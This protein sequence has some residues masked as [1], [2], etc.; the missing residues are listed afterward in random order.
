[1][2]QPVRRLSGHRDLSWVALCVAVGALFSTVLL[3]YLEQ[4]HDVYQ[5]GYQVAAQTQEHSRLLEENRRLVVEVALQSSV[6][7]LEA[8]A[9]ETLGLRPTTPEQII[10]VEGP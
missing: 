2:S 1:M 10:T 5:L 3:A 8:E 6:P 7:R 9:I 4:R